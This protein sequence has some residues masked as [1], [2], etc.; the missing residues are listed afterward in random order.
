[1][2]ALVGGEANVQDF[3]DKEM[4]CVTCARDYITNPTRFQEPVNVE[5]EVKEHE[6]KVT[7]ETPAQTIARVL[8]GGEV[9]LVKPSWVCERPED[10]KFVRRQDLPTGA[11][12]P[13]GM[14]ARYAKGGPI[15]GPDGHMMVVSY[16]W[17]SKAHPDPK[18][19]HVKRLRRF[20]KVVVLCDALERFFMDWGFLGDAFFLDFLSLTQVDEAGRRSDEELLCFLI[21]LSIINFL[22]GSQETIVLQLTFMKD[23]PFDDMNDTPYEKRGWCTFEETTAGIIKPK[24]LIINLGLVEDILFT[25]ESDAEE[26]A[27]KVLLKGMTGAAQ[28]PVTPSRMSQILKEKKFTNGADLEKVAKLYKVFFEKVCV[29]AKEL[30]LYGPHGDGDVKLSCWGKE[31]AQCLADALPAFTTCKRLWFCTCQ[32]FERE[33][34]PY[35]GHPFGND[36]LRSLA[37]ALAKMPVLETLALGYCEF[38][39]DGLS[40]L[41][42][43]LASCRSLQEISLPSALKNTP[44][45]A[46][47]MK[48]EKEAKWYIKWDEE[49]DKWE[50]RS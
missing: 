29:E 46:S 1:M 6:Q 40:A 11:F 39:E 3:L 22:Y 19:F 13:P 9:K 37:P 30:H 5:E 15:G 47:F 7:R 32:Q 24:N 36:G 49:E 43:S 18:G 20:F 2:K 14:A 48:A 27:K 33:E 21:G 12:V 34:A 35:Y 38:G 23:T 10:W 41:Q 44:A 25:E 42:E 17:F 31:E 45:G 16:G 4:V 26:F 8:G 50:L 28:P